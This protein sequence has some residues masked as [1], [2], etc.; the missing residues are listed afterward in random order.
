MSVRPRS[1]LLLLSC[2]LVLAGMACGLL[3]DS[4]PAVV[5][6]T[7]ESPSTMAVGPSPTAQAQLSYTDYSDA[8]LGLSLRYPQSWVRERESDRLIIASE[9]ELLTSDRFER[10]G[11][12]VII[13][14]APRADFPG[15]TLQ[16]AFA[17]ALDEFELASTGTYREEPT[18][19]TIAGREAIV[20][21]VEQAAGEG[22]GG[23]LVYRMALFQVQNR[24]AIVAGVTLKQVEEQYAPALEAII[25]S[26]QLDESQ[27]VD[28]PQPQGSLEYGETVRGTVLSGDASAWTFIGVEGETVD[29]SVRP[30]AEGL[31]VTVDLLDASHDSLLDSGPVDEAFGT[32]TIRG[33]NLPASD[34]FTIVVRG[35]G[36]ASG[37]YELQVVESG[38]LSA[39]PSISVGATVEGSLEVNEQD[40]YAFRS[41]DGTP[42]TFLVE[43]EGELDVVVELLGS[44]GEVIVQEDSTYGREQ[45]PFA[46]QADAD[47]VVRVRG[48]AGAAGD[49]VIAVQPGEVTSGAGTTVSASDVLV[50]G[51]DEG[52]DFPFRA[53]QDDVVQAIVQPEGDLDVVVEAWNDDTDEMEQRFDE[54]YGREEVTFT[55]AETGN[56]FFKVVGFEGQAG[57]YTI[58]LIGPPTT[59]F[60]LAVGDQVQADL[61]QAT[62]IDYHLRLDPGQSVV[63]RAQPDPETDVTVGLTNSAGDVLA[64]LDDG[65]SGEVEELRYTAAAD[66]D[67]RAII[68]LRVS[69][70]FAEGGGTFTLSL[71]DG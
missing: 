47:Y 52:H 59:I 22:S 21:T 57:S 50:D 25:N 31:D 37:D 28:V 11:A 58:D 45:M 18:S 36:Q 40:D 60:E 65:F 35:F 17:G 70:F 24:V 29:V 30:L 54:S 13:I 44:D 49:Y 20:A 56:Y 67:E 68:T 39:A 46:P 63:I 2:L 26:L 34:E 64:A 16:D 27:T 62:Y 9:R 4:Q 7:T 53:T 43:P 69:D 42:V 14:V 66:S 61:G 6:P 3:G 48:F 71:Q 23:S 1:G 32:E 33:L 5:S 55:V 12:G 38:A 8:Q 19:T 15:D 10:Q 51:T 41:S